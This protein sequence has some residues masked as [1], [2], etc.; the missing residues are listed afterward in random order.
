MMCL[1]LCLWQEDLHQSYS[2]C[3]ALIS[4]QVAKKDLSS[5]IKVTDHKIRSA[6]KQNVFCTVTKKDS[7]RQGKSFWSSILILPAV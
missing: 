7:D 3:R 6:L 4:V 5:C 2:S 1:V